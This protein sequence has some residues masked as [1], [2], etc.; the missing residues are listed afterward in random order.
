MRNISAQDYNPAKNLLESELSETILCHLFHS[1]TL[2]DLL[3]P[4]LACSKTL[5]L[6]LPPSFLTSI[7]L[8]LCSPYLALVITLI[9]ERTQT[10]PPM[11]QH[12]TQSEQLTSF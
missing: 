7:V 5:L 4:N 2:L 6:D 11:S 10:W 8:G 1:S 12:D 3:V 9:P